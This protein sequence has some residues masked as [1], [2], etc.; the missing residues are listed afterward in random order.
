MSKTMSATEYI[1]NKLC[2]FSSD[3]NEH[4]ETL[5]KYASECSSIA[6]LGVRECIST[7][8]FIYGLKH[9]QQSKKILYSVDILDVPD[10]GYVIEEAKT[11]NV[12]MT[13][14]KESSLDVSLPTE[15]DM[16]FIDT[17]HIYAQLKREL[18]RY[19]PITKKYIIM[20]DTEVDKVSGEAVRLGCDIEQLSAESGFPSDEI[21][22]GLG[23]AIVEFMRENSNTWRF[24]EHFSNNNGLTILERIQ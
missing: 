12:D 3:I 18:A 14:H 1:F 7:W 6:E 19:A 8:A 5:A 4:M 20:H 2:R 10:I 11:N 15:I 23:P 16:V 13:F 21:T 22:K 17:W 24:K 9:N